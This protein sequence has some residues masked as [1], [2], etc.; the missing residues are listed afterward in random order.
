[1]NALRTNQT[2]KVISHS[3]LDGIHVD[4][5]FDHAEAREFS[6][7]VSAEGFDCLIC[8]ALE[9]FEALDRLDAEYLVTAAAYNNNLAMDRQGVLR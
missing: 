2:Y 8:Q 5:F 9:Q 4:H 7:M 3:E 6:R 1:M